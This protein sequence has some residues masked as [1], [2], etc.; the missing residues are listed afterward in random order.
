[1]KEFKREKIIILIVIILFTSTITACNQI[2]ETSTTNISLNDPIIVTKNSINIIIDPRIELLSIV[3]Y[4]SS[5]KEKDECLITNSDFEYRNRVDEYFS[6]FKSHEAVKLFD[7]LSNNSFSYDAPPATMLYMTKDF[8]LRENIDISDDLI[9]RIGKK[10]NI[11]K[12]YDLLKNFSEETKF[13]DFYNANREYYNSLIENTSN[14][15]SDENKIIEE[16]EEFYGIKQESYNLVLVSLYGGVGYGIKLESDKN[17]YDVYSIIGSNSLYSK[18]LPYFGSESSFNY[19]QRHEFSHSFVNPLTEKYWN[20][21]EKYSILY[22]PLEE[23]MRK[24]AYTTWESCLNEHI[25]R[26]ITTRFSYLENRNWGYTELE[27]H[28]SNRFLYIDKLLEKLEEYDNNRDKYPT[29][30]SFYPELLKG[31]DYYLENPIKN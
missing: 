23:I 13:N 27:M 9:I 5:Y 19:L 28:K 10:D 17:K 4:L 30:E 26:T 15:I 24:Q 22:N 8:Q 18:E 31:L 29:F 12:L 20:E 21:A 1:M 2:K 7:K 25:I 11:E 16:L 6:P 14:T 3:Q